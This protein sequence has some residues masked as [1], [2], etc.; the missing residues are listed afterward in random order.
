MVD[1]QHR[2][3]TEGLGIRHLRL[4]IGNSMGGMHTWI[5]GV[6]HPDFMDA[7]V[8]MAAQPSEMSAR[9]WMLRRMLIE[10]IRSDPDY[11]NGDY[12][13]QPR[14]MK[15]ASVFYAIATNGGTLAHQKAAPSRA[16]ADKLVEARLAAPFRADANDFLYQWDSSRDYNPS[17]GLERIEAALLAI[18]AA[19]DERNPPETG[20]MER[21]LKRVKKGRLHLIPASEETRGHGTTGMARIWKQQLQEFLQSVPQRAM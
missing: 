13:T 7:L 17:P 12:T 8:P 1:A 10:T 18:N 11:N 9:N 14:S 20:L 21:E 19:D 4:V 3:L 16:Q 15:I 2:L 6:K 5:W